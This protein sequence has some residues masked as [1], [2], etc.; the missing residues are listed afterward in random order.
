MRTADFDYPLPAELIAQTPA[1]PR[2]SSRLLVVRRRSGA[3]EHRIFRDICDY[4]QPGDVLLRNDTRVIA[5]RLWGEKADSGG[6]VE[7]LLLR[8]AAASAWEALVRPANR[9]RL[10]SR[11]LFR[12]SAAGDTLEARII[13]VKQEGTR[14]LEFPPGA[15]PERLGEMP[16]PP[17][18][19]GA[20]D[21]PERYQTVYAR[22]K[23]SAAAPTAGLHFTPELLARLEAKG[24]EL[25]SLTLHVGLDTFRPVRQGD[26]Q[27]HRIHQEFY[28]L[29]PEVALRLTAAAQEGRRVVCV[30]TTSVRAI[31]D[32]ARRSGWSAS[33]PRPHQ[34][35]LLPYQ[36]LTG[37][38]ILPGHP[39][40]AVD[41]LL[42][43]FHLP[44]T[45][46]LM[47]VSAFAGREQVLA[48]YEEAIRHRYRFYSFGDALLFL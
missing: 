19:H 20:L 11:I 47:L 34:P 12:N 3:L 14:V 30:G 40:L 10:G 27:Q 15:D 43:N 25:L 35:P 36:G 8:P 46:L 22:E 24:V 45:T 23:G 39:F 21:D 17:Y 41:A 37:L 1:E 32:A 7:A 42:T 38:Y 28:R 26:P 44:H 18:I 16:L 31:E 29:T 48:A 33:S 6:K 4:L 2:D 9:L 13:A 5:A